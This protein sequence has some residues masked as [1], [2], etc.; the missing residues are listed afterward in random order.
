MRDFTGIAR[1][2]EQRKKTKLAKEVS[3]FVKNRRIPSSVESKECP[4][5]VGAWRLSDFGFR[6]KTP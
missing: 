6:S 1:F 4:E 2:S 5:E 3:S